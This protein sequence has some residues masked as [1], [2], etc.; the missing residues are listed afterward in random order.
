MAISRRWRGMLGLRQGVVS[1]VTVE[2]EA[3]LEE[4]RAA[5]VARDEVFMA[6]ICMLGMMFVKVYLRRRLVE[7]GTKV[8]NEIMYDESWK[9][10]A[11]MNYMLKT[12]TRTRQRRRTSLACPAI[13]VR[14]A[15]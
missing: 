1:R 10:R 15:N 9:K 12:E 5:R 14:K 3:E 4:R 6:A 7:L 8:G 13:H 2:A 11:A